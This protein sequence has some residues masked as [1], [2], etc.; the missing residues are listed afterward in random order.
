MLNAGA[1]AFIPFR[2]VGS[3]VFGLLSPPAAAAEHD[4]KAEVAATVDAVLKAGQAG[5]MQALRDLYAPDCTF[6]DEFAPF[7]WSGPHAIDSYF[8]SG[9]Q[10]YQQ[11]QHMN[12]KTTLSPPAFVYVAADRALVVEP[13]SGTATVHGKPYSLQG[14]YAYTLARIDGRWKITSQTWTKTT[15]NRDPYRAD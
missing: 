11:T 3:L 6:I 8:A 1:L 10:M 5:D 14:A 2:G 13:L 15:E 4:P 12:G 7:L 9:F